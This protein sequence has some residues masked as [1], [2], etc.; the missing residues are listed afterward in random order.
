[1]E[2]SIGPLHK[3]VHTLGKLEKTESIIVQVRNSAEKILLAKL[4]SFLKL[5][6]NLNNKRN[7]IKL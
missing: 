3:D 2:S 5:W 1:M 4:A 6:T 7:R